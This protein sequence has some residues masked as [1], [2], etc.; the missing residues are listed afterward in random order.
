[1][2]IS[3]TTQVDG[4]Q[5]GSKELDEV[6]EVKRE[7]RPD[8]F[9]KSVLTLPKSSATEEGRNRSFKSVT[10]AWS[11]FDG[12]QNFYSI[13]I[14]VPL[15]IFGGFCWLVPYDHREDAGAQIASVK[16][17]CFPENLK[18][19]KIKLTP[20][21]GYHPFRAAYRSLHP[22]RHLLSIKNPHVPW[23]IVK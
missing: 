11:A 17:N 9:G 20:E 4:W 8:H 5:N 19:G 23:S 13:L 6:N 1:V 10:V 12:G 16:V 7:H 2:S 14:I 3:G 21:K 22:N 18:T 15:Q